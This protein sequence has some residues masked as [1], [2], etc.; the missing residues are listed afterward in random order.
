MKGVEVFLNRIYIPNNCPTN[1]ANI[2]ISIVV[3]KVSPDNR[4][5]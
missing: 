4:K 2:T 3:E 5:A 1:I